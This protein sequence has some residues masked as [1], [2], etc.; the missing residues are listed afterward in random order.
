MAL[1]PLPEGR[2][3]TNLR[4]SRGC[5]APTAPLH[6]VKQRGSA[7]VVADLAS[8]HAEAERSNFSSAT[9]G[10]HV[11]IPL[12]CGRRGARSPSSPAGW[13]P[14]GAP[15]DR[16][17]RTRSSSAWRPRPPALPLCGAPPLFRPTAVIGCKAPCAAII[18]K[19]VALPQLVSV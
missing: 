5:P 7:S 15:S 2:P 3:C 4:H 10:N 6:I 14:C 16:S 11:F 8:R 19:G 12:W 1:S 18:R 9:A 17:R 13:T